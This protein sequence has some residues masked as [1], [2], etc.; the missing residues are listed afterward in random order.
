MAIKIFLDSTDITADLNAQYPLPNSVSE[1]VFPDY[2][3]SKWWDL[4]PAIS[5]HQELRYSFFNDDVGVHTLKVEDTN[6][7]SMNVRILLR[8]KYTSRNR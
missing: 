5:A 6:G 4:L 3:R 2:S 8:T 1:G 7:Q